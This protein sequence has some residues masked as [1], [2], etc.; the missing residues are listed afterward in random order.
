MNRDKA[1]KRI[2]EL[3][4]LMEVN[5]N[6]LFLQDDTI[7]K[8]ETAYLRSLI[9]KL[10]EQVDVLELSGKH[11]EIPAISV[12]EKVVEVVS[13]IV[14]RVK[15]AESHP[16]E[17][18]EVAVE[19]SETVKIPEE[20]VEKPILKPVIPEQMVVAKEVPKNIP[21]EVPEPEVQ[22][23]VAEIP[24]A[25]PVVEVKEVVKKSPENNKTP[26]WER[27]GGLYDKIRHSRI[28]SIK[29][30]ISISKRYEFQSELFGKDPETYNVCMKALDSC[31][32]MESAYALL[33]DYS[34]KFT[35]DAE[36]ELVEELKTVLLRRYM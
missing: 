28:D 25:P 13:P 18:E 17:A 30:A 3:L 23:P 20:V 19:K 15:E 22:T 35:W 1:H 33:N 5:N 7:S 4:E 27:E 10:F 8:A 32:S 6:R 26:E 34:S 31:D 21:A 11:V 24:I 9:N 16:I 29:K 2:G 36:N 12:E 14:E